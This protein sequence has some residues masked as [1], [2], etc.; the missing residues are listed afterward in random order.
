MQNQTGPHA[1]KWDLSGQVVEVLDHDSY[2]V[3]MDGSGRIT[4]RN[5]RFLKEIKTYESVIKKAQVRSGHPAGVIQQGVG[6]AGNTPKSDRLSDRS[7]RLGQSEIGSSDQRLESGDNSQSDDSVVHDIL[8]KSKEFCSGFPQTEDSLPVAPG[9]TL[10]SDLQVRT[11]ACQPCGQSDN[12]SGVRA[13]R[14]QPVNTDICTQLVEQHQGS[15]VMTPDKVDDSC[16]M[17]SVSRAVPCIRA[18]ST[19]VRRSPCRLVVGDLNDRC[20]KTSRKRKV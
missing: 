11:D 6:P 19:R 3:K 12:Q 2:M 14:G 16:V 18:P 4:K 20:W 5:R 9:R 1:N 17:P 15:D 13:D 7:D 8:H 10:S